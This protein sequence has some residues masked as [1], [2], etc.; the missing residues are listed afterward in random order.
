MKE[1]EKKIKVVSKDYSK[2]KMN[3]H[4]KIENMEMWVSDYYAETTQSKAQI[5]QLH[6]KTDLFYKTENFCVNLNCIKPSNNLQKDAITHSIDF[7][8]VITINATTQA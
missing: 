3:V 7:Q 6:F 2:S 8:E 4:M 1:I 5:L